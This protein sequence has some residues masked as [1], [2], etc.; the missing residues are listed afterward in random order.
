[1]ARKGQKTTVG[2]DKSEIVGAIPRACSEELAA[3]EFLEDMRGWTEQPCC[4]R[5]GDTDV[6][7]MADSETGGR[8]HRCLWRC[9][10]CKKQYTVRIGT[11]LED[12][13]I[14]LRHWCFAFW[15]ACSSKKGVSALQVKRQTGLSYKSALFLMHRIRWAMAPT[16]NGPTLTGTVEVDETY[17]GGKPR[18]KGQSG[19]GR[20]TRKQPVIGMVERGGSVRTRVIPDVTGNTLKAAIDV[21][22]SKASRLVTDEWPAYRKV[23]TE[24]A[25][26]HDIIK[27]RYKEYVRGDV[28]TN[29]IESFFALLKRGIIGVYHNVSLKHLQRYLDEFEFRY[30]HRSVDDGERTRQAIR[31]AVGK[32]LQYREPLAG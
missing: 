30:N 20:S 23:G 26:G 27:H 9:R 18:Y 15:A 13:R 16:D 4:P 10:G 6:Y 25:G 24:F 21:H 14:P 22:V 31:G 5:C 32:R 12:S 1:M 19:I 7:Q 17:V 2:Q 3:V 28:T 8:N 29:T 11:V